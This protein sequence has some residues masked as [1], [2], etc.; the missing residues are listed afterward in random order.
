M[1][2]DNIKD[3]WQ[4]HY[5]QQAESDAYNDD[6]IYALMK[7]KSQSVLASIRK[8]L[9]FEMA[10]TAF[11]MLFFVI[12]PFI[13]E[14]ELLQII[15]GVWALLCGIFLVFY[16][17]KYKIIESY[18]EKDGNLKTSLNL[19]I[20]KLEH[21]T[22]YYFWSNVILIPLVHITNFILLRFFDFKVFHNL[23]ETNDVVIYF[24]YVAVTSAGM[25][26]FFHWYI[27]KLYGKYI[28]QLK[29]YLNELNEM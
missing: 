28:A 26:Y 11:M 19:L 6:A 10:L 16:L 24:I 23:A 21:Y 1:E 20:R 13:Y 8:N 25:I 4:Q 2:L 7:G 29:N 22:K 18:E 5:A 9:R 15:L 14:G 27:Q 3:I 17:Q 12:M